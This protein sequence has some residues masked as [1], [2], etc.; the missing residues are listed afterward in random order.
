L[1]QGDAATVSHWT[2]GAH[3]GTHVDAPSHF[4]QGGRAVDEL[5]WD[6]FCRRVYVYPCRG[7]SI[8]DARVI[9]AMC[10]EISVDWA[11]MGVLFQTDNSSRLNQ[12]FYPGFVALDASGAQALVDH[13][14]SLV[15]IDYLSIET[16]GNSLFP[17]HK[18]L[19]SRDVAIIEGLDLREV[20]G[21]SYNLTC[22]AIRLM[23]ADGAPARAI[24]SQGEIH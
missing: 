1:D 23:G 8:I 19:L 15:G 17:A 11:R 6:Y 22:L 20:P 9:D 14:I 21:G 7:A 13:G 5:P 4:I 24:L 12:P 18:I 16:F 10:R 2:I 3:A